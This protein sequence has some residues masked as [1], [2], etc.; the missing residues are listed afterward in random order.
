ME[1]ILM[2]ALLFAKKIVLTT[3]TVSM[4]RVAPGTDVSLAGNVQVRYEPSSIVVE[5][6]ATKN[7]ALASVC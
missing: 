5:P 1:D 2:L 3:A 7:E 4:F 6:I